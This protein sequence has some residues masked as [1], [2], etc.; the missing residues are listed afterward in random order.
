MVGDWPLVEKVFRQPELH[1]L[2]LGGRRMILTLL[3]LYE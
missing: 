3:T 1:I 2:S